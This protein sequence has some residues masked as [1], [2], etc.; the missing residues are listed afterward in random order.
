MTLAFE[1][2]SEDDEWS[3]ELARETKDHTGWTST[4]EAAPSRLAH[5]PFGR[6]AYVEP[7]SER[8]EEK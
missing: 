6:G 4:P 8:V 2:Y 1:M 5:Q 3:R 7:D